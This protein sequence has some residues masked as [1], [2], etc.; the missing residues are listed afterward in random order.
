MGAAI[1]HRRDLVSVAYVCALA[2][3]RLAAVVLDLGFDSLLVA[4]AVLVM[5]TLWAIKHNAIH[6]SVFVDHRVD[7]TFLALLGVLTGSASAWTR[8]VHCEIHHRH[9]NGAGDWTTVTQA[10]Q[11]RWPALRLATYPLVVAVR[12]LSERRGYLAGK[13]ALARRVIG[14]TALSAALVVAALVASPA[15]TLWYVIVPVLF[16]QWFLIAMNYLQHA[17]CKVGAP[18]E[19]SVNDTGRVFN[20]LLLNLGYHAAH[21]RFPDRHWSE[22]PELHRRHVAPLVDR[23]YNR[24]N[25]ARRLIGEIIIPTRR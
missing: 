7:R 3:G 12:L 8:V 11:F 14:E 10:P 22:L 15:A 1:G 2:A 13:P 21:H 9:N 5:P 18:L 16:G 23:R 6:R 20:L 25:F 4:C 17:G 19:H 24:P